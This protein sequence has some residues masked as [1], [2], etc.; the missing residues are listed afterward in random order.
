MFFLLVS[1]HVCM[2]TLC[3]R[4]FCKNKLPQVHISLSIA[5]SREFN[6]RR[7]GGPNEVVRGSGPMSQECTTRAR[8][9]SLKGARRNLGKT[10]RSRASPK[11]YIWSAALRRQPRGLTSDYSLTQIEVPQPKSPAYK[12]LSKVALS[13]PR[14]INEAKQEKL[15]APVSGG[16]EPCK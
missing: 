11:W 1:M 3:W 8:S 10:C 7:A 15:K 6:R 9:W 4:Q 13:I 5:I 16:F 12:A 14:W 2:L